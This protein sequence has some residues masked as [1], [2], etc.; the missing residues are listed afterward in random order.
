MGLDVD[1]DVKKLAEEIKR[2]S[3]GG[4]DGKTSV[5]QPPTEKL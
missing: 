5:R 4:P 2:L 3:T 1:A